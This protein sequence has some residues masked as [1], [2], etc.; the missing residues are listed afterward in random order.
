MNESELISWFDKKVHPFLEKYGPERLPSLIDDYE[1]LRKLAAQP[2]DVTVCFLGNSGV[3][4]ST[5]LNA[6]AAG[7]AQVLPSGGIGPL[8]AQATEVHYSEEPQFK[9]IYH[10]KKHLWQLT[11]AL[12]A[13]I[14]QE[15]KALTKAAEGALPTVVSEIVQPDIDVQLD[16]DE[17][18]QALE[19]AEVA[20]VRAE[21][22]A[23]DK[24]AV[25]DNMDGLVKQARH[26][27]CADQ[28]SDRPLEYLADALRTACDQK[29]R[30]N[31]V[32]D[33]AD[34]QRM[35]RISDILK[36]QKADRSFELRQGDDKQGFIRA[37]GEHAAGFISPL[38][39]K[40]S[41][42]W[43]SP[44]LKAGVKLVDLPGVGIARDAY[45]DVTKKYIRERARG[46]ILV[47]DRAGPTESSIDLLRT[48]GYWERLVGA[49]DDPASDPCT[50]M[51]AVT[52]VD[53]VAQTEW[54]NRK[55]A[56]EV[57]RPALRKAEVFNDLVE[58]F[59]PRM[60]KQITEQL[61]TL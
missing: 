45:R 22:D 9:V 61:G 46:V 37:L 5:L 55:A 12:E 4:K 18:A 53:D 33:A 17:R 59:K 23:A 10:S 51:I 35:K 3:G 43:P 47:V 29:P 58:E 57:G 20:P 15:K 34:S 6:L 25:T 30:W 48:S 16:E 7:S 14:F 24:A 52:R 42:G 44:I 36:R 28:F 41:V 50:M 31:Q 11:F 2:D 40:I 39:E 1:R 56:A 19:D 38:I 54:A 8:T 49:S 21:G 60:R 27:V 32:I 26:I 13:R